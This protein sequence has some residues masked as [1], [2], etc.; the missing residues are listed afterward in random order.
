MILQ[1]KNRGHGCYVIVAARHII[2]RNFHL[3]QINAHLIQN[4]IAMA[5]AVVEVTLAQIV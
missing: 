4:H 2:D 1:L 5:Q 3:A